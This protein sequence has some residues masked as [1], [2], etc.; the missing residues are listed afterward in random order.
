MR[1]Q[2]NFYLYIQFDLNKLID[3]AH[4]YVILTTSPKLE[5]NNVGSSNYEMVK[6]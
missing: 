2:I 1:Q 4:S 5:P 6:G 3:V